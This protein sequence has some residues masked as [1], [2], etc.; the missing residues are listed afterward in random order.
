[1]TAF[2]YKSSREAIESFLI[3]ICFDVESRIFVKEEISY[4]YGENSSFQNY[5]RQNLLNRKIHRLLI[6]QIEKYYSSK[7]YFHCVFEAVKFFEKS[8]KVKSRL[9]KDGSDLMR[10][11]FGEGK[12]LHLTSGETQTE[13]NIENGVRD[14]AVG[15]MS[16]IRN[17][18]AHELASDVDYTEDECL[19]ILS[20]ISMLMFY[21]DK[22]VYYNKDH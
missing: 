18:G 19:N 14:I 15:V 16:L 3:D 7:D 6:N 20:T 12:V 1:M 9:Q 4:L 5:S 8:V 2:K 10:N 21:L 17:I 13:K 11:A 22:A